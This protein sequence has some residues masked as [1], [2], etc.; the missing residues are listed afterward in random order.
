VHYAA[1]VGIKAQ[2]TV[3]ACAGLRRVAAD[4]AVGFDGPACTEAG[5][6][7]GFYALRINPLFCREEKQELTTI[8]SHHDS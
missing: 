2:K 5:V 4:G 8:N 1:V 3:I 6:E 7:A